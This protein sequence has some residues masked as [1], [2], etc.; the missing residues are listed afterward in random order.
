M[1]LTFIL[2]QVRKSLQLYFGLTDGELMIILNYFLYGKD[3]KL[4]EKKVIEMLMNSEKYF[5]LLERLV[6]NYA[7]AEMDPKK[8]IASDVQVYNPVTSYLLWRKYG[9]GNGRKA[10]EGMT[11]LDS[12][13]IELFKVKYLKTLLTQYK[14]G[15]MT[16]MLDWPG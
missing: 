16:P 12:K 11:G 2:L 10:S 3:L 15:Q 5:D 14:F 7:E 6:H 13:T 8:F 9:S 1:I 4:E